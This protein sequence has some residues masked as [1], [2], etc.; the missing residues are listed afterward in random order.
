MVEDADESMRGRRFAGVDLA[1]DKIE[2]PL[3]PR[4]LQER[5]VVGGIDVAAVQLPPNDLLGP[6]DA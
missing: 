2:R 3:E 1:A 4:D 5:T 6:P